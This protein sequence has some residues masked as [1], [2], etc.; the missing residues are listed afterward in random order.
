MY[1]KLIIRRTLC[2]TL[3][4]L[5]RESIVTKFHQCLQGG[6]FGDSSYTISK[7]HAGIMER[8]AT[9]GQHI[10]V[11]VLSCPD[12]VQHHVD[13]SRT[14]QING[15]IPIKTQQRIEMVLDLLPGVE[16]RILLADS[17]VLHDGKVEDPEHFNKCMQNTKLRVDTK[18]QGVG[19]STFFEEAGG[20]QSFM[21]IVDHFYDNLRSKVRVGFET[22][23]DRIIDR[24]L[25]QL[26]KYEI[27]G[28]G[29]R[30]AGRGINIG[31]QTLAERIIRNS[32]AEMLTVGELIRSRHSKPDGTCSAVI[33]FDQS[34]VTG[35]INDGDKHGSKLKPGL[36]PVPLILANSVSAV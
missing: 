3:L 14:E 21:N 11:Y 10:V 24:R 28:T 31:P 34:T 1:Q 23:E 19:S 26:L 18:Y 29:G 15:N 7:K 32:F 13:D 22:T 4:T 36:C 27:T 17:E 35:L 30:L 12:Y 2:K 20:E 8:S 9:A 33:V 6:H 5:N 16:A 25:T